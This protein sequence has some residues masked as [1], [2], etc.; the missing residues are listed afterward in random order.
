VWIEGDDIAAPDGR[1][2]SFANTL[3]VGSLSVV[4]VDSGSPRQLYDI[5]RPGAPVAEMS[6]WSDDG[7]TLYFKSHSVTGA[8]SIWSVPFAGGTPRKLIELGDERL[9]AD[10][11]AFRIANGRIYFPLTDRQATVW[12]I[13]VGK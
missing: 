7:R 4:A 3:L 6:A 8:A 1:Y 11:F 12:V 13:E 9:R 2:L 5:A 10:R